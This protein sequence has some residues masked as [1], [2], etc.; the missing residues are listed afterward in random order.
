MHRRFP[1]HPW[2]D[3]LRALATTE[4]AGLRRIIVATPL[5]WQILFYCIPLVFILA[6]SFWIV[7]DYQVAPAWTLSSYRTLLQSQVYGDATLNSLW[8]AGATAA[9][10]TILAFPLA[11]AIRL[12]A[13]GGAQRLLIFCLFVPFFSSYLIRVSAWQLW[14]DDNG[15]LAYCLRRVGLLVRPLSLIYTPI[16]TIVGLLSFLIPIA[17]LVI[18]IGLTQIDSTLLLAARNLGATRS[19]TFVHIELPLV[20]HSIAVS[21]LLTFIISLGDFISQ[22]MLGG[23]K[24]PT[25]SMLI[26]DRVKI[27]DWPTASALGVMMLS[28]SVVSILAMAKLIGALPGVHSDGRSK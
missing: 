9:L 5:V 16:A 18:Y 2:S 17:S 3:G 27:G 23:G 28:L 20:I 8:F 13:P 14:L 24:V 12:Q 6:V 11:Y 4:K 7:R 25:L 10:G 22:G 26:I 1:N 21:F 19:Q 15:I